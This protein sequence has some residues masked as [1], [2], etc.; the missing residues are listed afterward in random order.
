MRI[1]II[2]LGIV[3]TATR[4]GLR[5]IDH[6]VV[7]YD[8]KDD[9]IINSVLDTEIV[10]LCV[11][12]NSTE[13]GECDVNQVVGTVEKLSSLSYKGIVAIKSTVIPGTTQIL[14]KQHPNLSICFVPEFLREKSALN[15]FINGHDILIVGTEDSSVFDRVVE[16]HG[17]IPQNIKQ[18][19]PTE[20]EISKYFCNLFNSLRITFANGMYEV[21]K[22][23]GAD[24]QQV[25]DAVIKRHNI[26]PEYLRCSEYL[27]GFGGHCLPKDSQAWAK[28]VEQL[29]LDIKL[30]DAMVKDNEKHIK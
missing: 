2:G 19:T 8:I 26:T 3:G 29:G 12:T 14:I 23:T 28:F 17:N 1:G 20:A 21:C 22:I 11:P 13:N 7:H 10:Y 16:C 30:F 6:D 5:Q 18:L 25:F 27:R 4:D 15:D 9:S 24:Y